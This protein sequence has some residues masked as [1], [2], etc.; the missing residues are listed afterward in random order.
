MAQVKAKAR[1]RVKRRP[2]QTFTERVEKGIKGIK[3]IVLG[4]QRP[5]ESR[6]ETKR[7]MMKVKRKK[8]KDEFQLPEDIA[9]QVEAIE[10]KSA[11]AKDVEVRGDLPETAKIV[12]GPAEEDLMR[13]PPPVQDLDLRKATTAFGELERQGIDPRTKALFKDVPRGDEERAPAAPK[14]PSKI[15]RIKSKKRKRY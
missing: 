13:A 2:A 10:A 15:I 3:D 6:P 9:K 5:S 4:G 8:R 1:A 7:P 12:P 14:K 11:K